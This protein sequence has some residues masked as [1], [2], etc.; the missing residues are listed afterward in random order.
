MVFSLTASNSLGQGKKWCWCNC[1]FQ[2]LFFN[3]F[4]R[5]YSTTMLLKSKAFSCTTFILFLLL[6]STEFEDF[7]LPWSQSSIFRTELQTPI[8]CWIFPL[9][10]LSSNANPDV[11]LVLLK[12]F[13]LSLFL[14]NQQ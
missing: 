8:V 11:A 1:C 6:S 10:C 7:L 2:L 14:Y 4:H 5:H 9:E 12:Q 13:D 3:Y